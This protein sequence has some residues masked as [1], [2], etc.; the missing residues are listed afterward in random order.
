VHIRL[1]MRETNRSRW[2]C[3]LHFRILEHQLR[4]RQVSF[5]KHESNFQEEV[6]DKLWRPPSCHLQI[7]R[8]GDNACSSL[9]RSE[10]IHKRHIQH[11]PPNHQQRVG[12]ESTET[13]GE[14][15]DKFIQCHEEWLLP[16]I[17]A[18]AV[19]GLALQLK[20]VQWQTSTRRL[21]PT[22]LD[23]RTLHQ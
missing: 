21:L 22:R 9:S 15:Q 5:V 18:L 23:A 8:N 2:L 10:S 12:C 11:R 16:N 14:R 13:D 1:A 6:D 17:V 19:L 4:S 7:S 3:R 20:P